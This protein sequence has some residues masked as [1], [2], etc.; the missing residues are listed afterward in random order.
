MRGVPLES[1]YRIAFGDRHKMMRL[2]TPYVIL[3]PDPCSARRVPAHVA[4]RPAS[5][6]RKATITNI[7]AFLLEGFPEA[8]Q[9]RAIAQRSDTIHIRQPLA[10]AAGR[11]P[12]GAAV[13]APRTAPWDGVRFIRTGLPCTGADCPF[14]FG[15]ALTGRP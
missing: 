9:A 11:D 15:G 5:S 1:G 2:A 12:P 4:C 14:G 6:S 10:A 13:Q 7:P 8:A 3:R